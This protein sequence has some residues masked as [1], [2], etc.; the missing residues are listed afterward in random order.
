MQLIKPGFI[1]YLLLLFINKNISN[2]ILEQDL[3]FLLPYDNFRKLKKSL[4]LETEMFIKE[5]IKR[6]KKDLF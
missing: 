5:E 6:F 4:K 2:T 1:D 3:N